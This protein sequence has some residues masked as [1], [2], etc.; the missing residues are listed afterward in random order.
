MIQPLSSSRRVIL[1]RFLMGGAASLSAPGWMANVLAEVANAAPGPAEIRLKLADFP[2]LAAVGGSIQLTFNPVQKPFTVNRV[3]ESEFI[4]LDSVCTHVGCT[5][6]TFVVEENRMRCPCHGSRYDIRGRVF[7]DA[8]GVSTEPA[9]RDIARYDSIYQPAK[10]TL[11]VI[12]PGLALAI[13]SI[14][15]RQPQQEGGPARVTLRFPVTAFSTYEI[16]HSSSLEGDFERISFSLTP[17]GP[18]TLNSVTPTSTEY[19]S[20]YVDADGPR[21][22]YVVAVVLT[23]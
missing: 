17:E 12:I 6:G 4:A 3:S 11:T 16:R 7:R 20:A 8:N 15:V 18:V 5:V 22:F 23:A 2:A 1:K 13:S 14:S 21:G 10:G 9:Q 19:I